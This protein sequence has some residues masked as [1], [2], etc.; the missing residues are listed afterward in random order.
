MYRKYSHLREMIEHCTIKYENNIAYKVKKTDENNKVYYDEITYKRLANE[1][2][3][4]ARA[5]MED[6]LTGKRIAVIG[7]NSYEW[8]VVFL[9]TVCSGGVIVPLD[10][11]LFDYELEDQLKRSEAVAIFYG[12]EFKERVG[13]YNIVKVCTAD[14]EFKD[15]IV[16]G[17]NAD[18]KAEYDKIEIDPYKMSALLFTS[19]TTS[20]S[21]A[22]MLSQ[23]NITSNVYGMRQWV[24]FY[25]TDVSMALLP[26]HHTFGMMQTMLFL[27]VGMCSVFCEGLR[28]AKCLNEYGVTLF[29]GVPRVIEEMMLA[30]QRKLAA[31]GKEKTVKMVVKVS[32]ALRKVGIDIRR[33]LFKQIIDGMGGRLRM[34]IIGAAPASPD[35][36]KFFNDIGVLSIQGYGLTESSPV[37][38]A[39]NETN[40]R[41]DSV[42][43][44]IPG[45]EVKIENPDENGIGE[46]VAKG[47]N[48]MLGYYN[49]PEKTAEVLKDGWL[50]TGD[51]GRK[52]KDG[53]IFICGRKKNVIVLSNGKNV[54]PEEIETLVNLSPAVKECIVYAEGDEIC[55]KAVID[56]KF[57]GNSEE[58]I[59][60]H[61]AEVNDQLIKYKKIGKI[62][63][64]ETEMAK[65]TTGKIKR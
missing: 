30:V 51:L 2:E 13:A 4:L 23:D 47:G 49:D 18:N 57:E 58:A 29:V 62:E 43:K 39:E 27:S 19:G 61:I 46:I 56:E 15:M 45:V 28:I 50:Y 11:G 40:M 16:R 54:F 26:L 33:K 5:F 10:R 59:K 53:F 34:V 14:D 41:K 44:A 32:N 3:G 65:T 6:G 7:K 21:K 60:E 24:K 38:S 31:T 12:P 52:D 37:I 17:Q 48:V 22:V 9:A 42:G 36:L 20:A 25:E 8:I 55:C 1:V 63:I 35:V 64:T